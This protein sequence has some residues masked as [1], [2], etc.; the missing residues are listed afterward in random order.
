MFSHDTLPV[1]AEFLR[2]RMTTD[3]QATPVDHHLHRYLASDWI[4]ELYMP[5]P[6]VDLVLEEEPVDLVMARA[7]FHVTSDGN[8]E[9][10][11]RQ[12]LLNRGG[13]L[14]QF[15]AVYDDD[16]RP[17]VDVI[18]PSAVI[19]RHVEVE[20][21]WR[22]RKFGQLLVTWA[23]AQLSRD[24]DLGL[25]AFDASTKYPPRSEKRKLQTS[26]KRTL[27]QLQFEPLVDDVYLLNLEMVTIDWT[28]ERLVK[29][30][31]R[32]PRAKLSGPSERGELAPP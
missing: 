19:L 10:G 22:G 26:I 11:R 4:V 20:E 16:G 12:A 8:D 29:T 2:M 1:P 21:E 24:A 30:A 6:A 28:M 32:R 3:M 23:M 15:A 31:G 13:D 9:N 14:A 18:S 25:L 5:G 27:R 7:V 17:M